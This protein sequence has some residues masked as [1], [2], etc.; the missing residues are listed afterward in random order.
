MIRTTKKIV[1]GPVAY[2]DICLT[3]IYTITSNT[4]N[5]LSFS[6]SFGL[7]D[8]ECRG[9]PFEIG[10]ITLSIEDSELR[11]SISENSL[12]GLLFPGSLSYPSRVWGVL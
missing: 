1:E 4:P 12:V 11:Q 6:V 5:S 2:E 3:A 9:N 10:I 7:G 8:L